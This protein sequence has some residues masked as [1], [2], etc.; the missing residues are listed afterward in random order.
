MYL[1]LLSSHTTA[2]N[3]ADLHDIDLETSDIM[4]LI[5]SQMGSSISDVKSAYRSAATIIP[6]DAPYHSEVALGDK[7]DYWVGVESRCSEDTML[8]VLL[9]WFFVALTLSGPN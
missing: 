3:V 4:G 8:W 7:R 6:T 2:A 1:A 5:D 9:P